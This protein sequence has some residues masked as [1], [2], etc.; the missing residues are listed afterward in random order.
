MA[1]EHLA[2]LA[3]APQLIGSREQLA[4]ARVDVRDLTT[5]QPDN[6]CS[7]TSQRHGI[8]KLA[9]SSH[10]FVAFVSA[11]R[12][13]AERM[14]GKGARSPEEVHISGVGTVALD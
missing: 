13:Q 7:Q 6:R 1:P 5:S 3:D 4:Q 14:R 2:T 9:G 11:K 12:C 8:G 10:L